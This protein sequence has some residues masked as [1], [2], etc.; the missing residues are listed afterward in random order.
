MKYFAFLLLLV[1]ACSNGSKLNIQTET[2]VYLSHNGNDNNNGS[3]EYPVLTLD[4]A[5]DLADNIHSIKVTSGSFQTYQANLETSIYGGFDDSFTYQ[6]DSLETVIIGIGG[7]GDPKPT[8]YIY[9]ESNIMVDHLTVYASENC[10][11]KPCAIYVYQCISNIIIQNCK[12]YGQLTSDNAQ[13]TYGIY[14]RDGIGELRYSTVNGGCLESEVGGT[15][16]VFCKESNAYIHHN[17]I[18]GGITTGAAS[19]G[20]YTERDVNRIEYNEINGGYSNVY[21]CGYRTG[22]FQETWNTTGADDSVQYNE[23]N[24]GV[25]YSTYAIIS[26]QESEQII[27]FNEIDGGTGSNVQLGIYIKTDDSPRIE[28]NTFQNCYCAIWEHNFGDYDP[29]NNNPKT[30]R[31]NLFLDSNDYFY[32]RFIESNNTDVYINN[33]TGQIETDIDGTNTLAY[34]MNTVSQSMNQEDTLFVTIQ[35]ESDTISGWSFVT[36]NDSNCIKSSLL[37]CSANNSYK[38]EYEFNVP[39]G[40][41]SVYLYAEFDVNEFSDSFFIGVNNQ[42]YEISGLFVSGTGW[43]NGLIGKYPVYQGTNYLKLFPREKGVYI[44]RFIIFSIML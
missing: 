14:F 36:K 30:V 39:S 3:I 9:N 23:I 42:T 43:K 29:G 28:E 32:K 41:D 10:T 5:I 19:H 44:N 16:G 22:D 17:I 24:G 35:A 33:L 21:A 15:I 31:Y 6:H 12:L 34:F 1:L 8:I 7:W 2:F 37:Q 18:N 13:S 27:K 26:S 25:G 11:K 40:I 4:K 38:M 20:I